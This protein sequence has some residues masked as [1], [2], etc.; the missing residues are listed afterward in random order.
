M[1]KN[2]KVE[3]GKTPSAV[4][5][6]P[7]THIK[8]GSPLCDG[9]EDHHKDIVHTMCEDLLETVRRMDDKIDCLESSCQANK[10]KKENE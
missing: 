7:C 5:S 2:G 1:I 3:I 4:S 6:K 10:E 9:E 8:Q